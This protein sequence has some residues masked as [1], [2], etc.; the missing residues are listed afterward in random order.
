MN[1]FYNTKYRPNRFNYVYN[2]AGYIYIKN[3]DEFKRLYLES[4]KIN[5]DKEFIELLKNKFNN[6]YY[7]KDVNYIITEAFRG[8]KHE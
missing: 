7:D 5:N 8:K 6:L 3:P 2:V 1:F 4:Y